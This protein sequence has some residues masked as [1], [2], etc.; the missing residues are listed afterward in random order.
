MKRSAFCQFDR[1]KLDPTNVAPGLMPISTVSLNPLPVNPQ[2]DGKAR[3]AN[4][5]SLRM[6]FRLPFVWNDMPENPVNT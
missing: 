6:T 3:G 5:V 1:V 2:S 4:W